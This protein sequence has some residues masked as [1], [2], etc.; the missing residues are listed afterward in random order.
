MSKKQNVF[1]GIIALTVYVSL[2]IIA[3]I[4]VQIYWIN[5]AISLKE[6][7]FERSVNQALKNVSGKLEKAQYANRIKK[8]FEYK[9]QGTRS[10]N[11]NNLTQS[12]IKIDS[13]DILKI[14]DNK[15]NYSIQEELKTDSG[16]TKIA[17]TKRK[18]FSTD[19][20]TT[21]DFTLPNEISGA[22]ILND[23]E[24]A[25]MQMEIIH[26]K[27]EMVN[28][29][30]DELIR[31][32]IYSS[33]PKLDTFLLDSLL[34]N[35]L[36]TQGVRAKYN[37]EINGNGLSTYHHPTC[38]GNVECNSTCAY[39]IQVSPDNVFFKPQ[40]LHVFF[41]GERNYLLKSMWVILS[42][43]GSIV[44]ILISSFFYS[45]QTIVRQKKLSVVK[46]DFIN[47]MTHEFKTPIS[48][49]SLATEMLSD[50]NIGASPDRSER[51]LKMI[52]EENKRL[53]VLVES[54]LQTALL[55]KGEFKLKKSDF[56][57]HEIILQSIKNIQ[58]QI[59]KQGGKI[60]VNLNA[61]NEI[62]RAH[63]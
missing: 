48:T 27:E 63:V 41:P 20:L 9:K 44:I 34:R 61:E 51:F 54:I 24:R 16:Q 15:V 22:T 57:L 52:Q 36:I 32:N 39:K 42:I 23:P 46:N 5:S 59:E 45:I 7:E 49:I 14:K 11:I 12:V 4:G 43:S 30:F 17:T 26:K 25:K 33:R 13:S 60:N 35:E 8:T 50:K 19:S 6:E 40:Y 38:E 56:N 29:I 3:L 28:D 62:G 10:Y 1:S 55:D 47:N 18:T 53:S 37:Y 21:A 31:V 58:L 2:A